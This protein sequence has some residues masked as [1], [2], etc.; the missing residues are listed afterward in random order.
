[1][2]FFVSPFEIYGQ[3]GLAEENFRDLQKSKFSAL[4]GCF[5]SISLFNFQNLIIFLPPRSD[6]YFFKP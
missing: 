4:S 1:M 6:R 5:R 3:F 2:L